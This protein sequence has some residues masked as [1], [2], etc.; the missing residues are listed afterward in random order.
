MFVVGCLPSWSQRE[1]SGRLH[2]KAQRPRQSVPSVSDASGR[3]GSH[4]LTL[5]LAVA[6][7]CGF[8]IFA[9]HRR[10]NN[11]ASHI[12]EYIE[13]TIERLGFT[14][15]LY[16]LHRMDPGMFPFQY[17]ALTLCAA[18]S[19]TI[20]TQRHLLKNPSEPSTSFARR[21]RPSTLVSRNALP[22]HFAKPTRV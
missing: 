4:L 11:S 22:R 3:T 9:E 2:Q 15:D 8:D 1:A 21:A 20:S 10:V 18:L 17:L 5:C 6:S 16:Y 13:G 12:N 14:P 19:L 7:K